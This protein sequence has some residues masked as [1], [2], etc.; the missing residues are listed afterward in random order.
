MSEDTSIRIKKEVKK[1]LLELDF[2]KRQS[3][4]DLVLYLIEYYLNNPFGKSVGGK[5]KRDRKKR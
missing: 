4:S 5:R 1:K 2:V 3:E